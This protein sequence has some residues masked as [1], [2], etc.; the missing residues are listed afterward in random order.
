MEA[1]SS[2]GSGPA[3]GGREEEA[4]RRLQ[5]LV[6]IGREEVELT[7]EEVRANDQRQEDEVMRR[8]LSFPLRIVE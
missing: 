3:G 4:L 1:S 7:E 8:S 2:S 6:G 5:E